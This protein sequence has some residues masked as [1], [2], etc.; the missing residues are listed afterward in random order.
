MKHFLDT[1]FIEAGFEHP[2]QLLSIGIVAEDGREYY[3]VVDPIDVNL[4]LADDWVR[5]NVIKYLDFSKGK[6]RKVIAKEIIEFVSQKSNPSFIGYY[7]VAPETRVL[8]SDLK[9]VPI[10]TLK[11]GDDLAGF[12]E[13]SSFGKEGPNVWRHWRKTQV[14]SY[15]VANLPC[16]EL[17][18]EDG[19]TITCTKDHRWLVNSGGT[20]FWRTTEQ[21]RCKGKICSRVVKPIDVWEE[22]HSYNGGYLAAALDGEGHLSCT[23]DGNRGFGHLRLG[24]SQKKNPMLNR[25]RLE[26]YNHGFNLSISPR[27]NNSGVTMIDICRKNDV[28]RFLGTFRPVRLLPKF[29]IDLIGAISSRSVKLINKIDVGI[30]KV[31]SIKTG[32]GTYLAEGFASHNCDYD[33]VVLCQLFGRMVDLPVGWPKYCLDLKQMAAESV[34]PR[35]PDLPDKIE[36]HAL[37]DAR[38]IKYRYDWLMKQYTISYIQEME[39][40]T[41]YS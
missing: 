25:V 8:T 24:F 22:D 7:C 13:F 9:W 18:F 3:A 28:L 17:F 1:E 23:I 20:K 26:L 5:D 33:W 21:L 38:E 10:E 2:I 40:M 4:H 11:V 16:Y 14:E 15:E 35:M 39:E 6:R 19:T 31:I 12:D 30:K 29:N 41:R 27:L 34:D 37:W 32:T 36:H